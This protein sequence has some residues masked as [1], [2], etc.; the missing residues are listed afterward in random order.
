MLRAENPRKV[1]TVEVI[2]TLSSRQVLFLNERCISSC[3]GIENDS[4]HRRIMFHPF[5]DLEARYS[6]PSSPL[7]SSVQSNYSPSSRLEGKISRDIIKCMMPLMMEVKPQIDLFA[8]WGSIEHL[9]MPGVGSIAFVSWVVLS[10]TEQL[11]VSNL[12]IFTFETFVMIRHGQ[13]LT[14][15]SAAKV[16]TRDARL[17]P[18]S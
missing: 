9:R 3:L 1:S 12:Y 2:E 17:K 16:W 13:H 8:A 15:T 4:W 14:R 7:V 6:L 5:L 10:A 11:L 18:L